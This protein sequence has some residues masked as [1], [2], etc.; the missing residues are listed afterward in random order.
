MFEN[1]DTDA[2]SYY[3]DAV[4]DAVI[5][6]TNNKKTN[7]KIFLILNLSFLGI[8]SFFG[9]SYFLQNGEE[10]TPI[11]KTK[12]M[13]VS[14]VST[15][16]SISQ[17][18]IDYAAEIEKLDDPSTDTEYGSQLTDYVDKEIKKASDNSDSQ[19]ENKESK[20]RWR[21][22]TIT[23]KKGDTLA[24]LAQKYYHDSTAYD[25][26]IRNNRELTEKS[27]VIYPGQELKISTKY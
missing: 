25:K 13:G 10:A 15:Q 16:G 2:N 7:N 4:K 1:K 24:T 3:T 23:V 9:Y 6:N 12:V 26:I 21:D 22:I 18:D 19:K 17:E 5:N 11:Q 27:H 14:H 8:I 20:E